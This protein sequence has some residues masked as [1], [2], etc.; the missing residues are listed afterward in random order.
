MYKMIAIYKK[1]QDEASFNSWYEGHKELAKKVPH[2][3]EIRL[4]Q[5]TGSPM[6]PSDLYLIAELVFSSEEKF[7][8]AM[9]SKENREAG[10]DAFA[11]AKDIISVHFAKETIEVVAP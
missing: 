7:Q 3:Q 5:I 4:T 10:K 8:E 6:G 1:P 2:V 9:K 11:H